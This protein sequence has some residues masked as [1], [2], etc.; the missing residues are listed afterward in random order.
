[1]K[2][3]D[4]VSGYYEQPDPSDE[5]GSGGGGLRK[6]LEDALA[7]NKRLAG[8]IEGEK[9]QETVT[10]ELKG[11]GLDP[12]IAKLIPADADPKQWVEENK[13]LFGSTPQANEQEQELPPVE[14]PPVTDPAVLLEQQALEDMQKAEAAGGP[15]A[16]VANDLLEQLDQFDGTKTEGELLA[17]LKS[18]GMGVV[19]D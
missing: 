4:R 19:Q 12:A 9:R 13:S 2:R 5:L 18:N 11:A 1:M 17:F 3:E 10:A 6:L 7:E 15:S 16:V 14:A 8:L